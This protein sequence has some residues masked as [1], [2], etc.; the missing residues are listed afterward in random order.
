[1]SDTKTVGVIGGLGP[2]ATLD[3]FERILKRTKALREQDHLRVII[4]NNTKIPDR[5]A[6]KR[7][8]GPSPGPALADAARGLEQAGAEFIV[9]ACNTTHAWE[10][11]IRAAISVPFISIIEETTKVVAELRPDG[12]GVLAVDA[13]LSSNL[14]Q[15]AL[16]KRGV[17]P[18]L[19]SADSQKTFMELV[20]RIKNGDTGD[21]VKR[22]MATLARKLEAQGAE[23][24]I[25][26]CTE[27]PIVLTADDIDGELVNSTDVLVERTIEF[28]GAELK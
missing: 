26:G 17:K 25:A 15:D 4:D 16:T 12:A 14:Y 2:F 11:E 1:M 28:A 21:T 7:G 18:V 22:S 13:C 5:N 24:I 6:Y 23:V 3:F 8:E 9:M 20:Y 10:A 27:V 19:L